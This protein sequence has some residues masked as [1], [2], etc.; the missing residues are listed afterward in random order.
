MND[1]ILQAAFRF[2]GSVTRLSIFVKLVFRV[3][4]RPALFVTK[5]PSVLSC[6]LKIYLFCKKFN[7]AREKNARTI[8]DQGPLFSLDSAPEDSAFV[9]LVT[10]AVKP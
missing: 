4:L 2:V 10:V 8:F 5:T 3:C 1:L 7:I 9:L 6:A